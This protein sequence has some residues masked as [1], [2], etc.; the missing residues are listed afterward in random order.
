MKTEEMRISVSELLD[1]C[2]YAIGIGAANALKIHWTKYHDY[3][4]LKDLLTKGIILKVKEKND[5]VT[6]LQKRNRELETLL[7]HD[8]SEIYRPLTENTEQ[9]EPQLVGD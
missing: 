4:R 2:G 5:L 8:I 7:Q 9:K 6:R 3:A 1:I